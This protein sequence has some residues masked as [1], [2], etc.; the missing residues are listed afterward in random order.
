MTL[1]KALAMETKMRESAKNRDADGFLQIVHPEAVMVCGGYRCTG[2]ELFRA[3]NNI[4]R[5]ERSG[6]L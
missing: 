6:E 1:E 4:Q 3:G 5:M 2:K